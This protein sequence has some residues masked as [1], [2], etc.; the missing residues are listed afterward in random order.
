MQR[1]QFSRGS[2]SVLSV[3]TLSACAEVHSEEPTETP[4]ARFEASER[5]TAELGVA[6]WEVWVDGAD[7]RVIGRDPAAARKLE[8]IVR[9]DAAASD[10]LQIE[11]VFPEAGELAITRAGAVENTTSDSLRRLG[12][13]V[14]SDLG[15]GATP[16]APVVE[17]R[18]IGT[19]SS[20][21]GVN[22]QGTIH[23]GWNLWG[24]T[25]RETV[26]G[27]CRTDRERDHAEIYADYG[28]FS[29]FVA[30]GSP[31]D[32]LDCTALF[33][34]SVQNGHWDDFHW[35]I[36]NRP[37]NLALA[38]VANQSST[39]PWGGF[40]HKATDGNTNGSWPNNSVTHTDYQTQ[41]WWQIDLGMVKNIG[42]VVL[43]NRTDCCAERL[44]DFDILV[45]HDGVNWQLAY[46]FTG[47]APARASF[48]VNTPARLVR[49]QLRGTNYLSLAEVQV[50][51]Q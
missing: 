17:E 37:V 9:P 35:R 3:L 48:P 47:P 12:A 30:W 26:G 34:M 2:I 51:A 36:F 11:V 6:H 5:S 43:H 20:E 16:V 24:Y 22:N 33:E 13:N 1:L 38:G 4:T 27:R 44:A 8:M 40:A 45:S 42:E 23:L 25:R 46:P 15:N 18:G 21:L 10:R 31:G 50:F 32:P 19:I 41:P 14:S 7:S 28:A 39:P 29:T 49:V